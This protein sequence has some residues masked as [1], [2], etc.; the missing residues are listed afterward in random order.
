M[1]SEQARWFRAQRSI[2]DEQRGKTFQDHIDGTVCQRE[3]QAEV[4]RLRKKESKLKEQVRKED[5]KRA[6]AAVKKQAAKRKKEQIAL[7]RQQKKA[8]EKTR[9][10][11]E[12]Q[13]R[14]GKLAP[15]EGTGT[16]ASISDGVAKPT[17][18]CSGNEEKTKCEAG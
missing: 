9:I 2:V 7:A 14:L 17:V 5:N 18:Q 13:F 8:A 6:K 1:S 12:K 4:N 3:L 11:K 15:K 16:S 10:R